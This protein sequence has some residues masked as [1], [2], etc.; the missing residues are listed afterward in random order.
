MSSPN[1]YGAKKTTVDG[2]VFDS[3]REAGH[4]QELRLQERAGLIRNLERQKVYVLKAAAEGGEGGRFATYRADFAFEERGRK[5]N[6]DVARWT[7]EEYE[8]YPVVADSKGKR[9]EAYMI[10]KRAMK[11]QFG[12]EV[13]E[14]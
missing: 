9:T 7:L 5:N 13:R 3:K 8:W 12:I 6:P 1:K 2:I 4:Y 11:A 14:L 10:K